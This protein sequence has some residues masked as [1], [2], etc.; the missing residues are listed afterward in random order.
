MRPGRSP[1]G[2]G[3]NARGAALGGGDPA[4]GRRRLGVEQLATPGG[5]PPSGHPAGSGGR[6]GRRSTAPRPRGADRPATKPRSRDTGRPAG[7]PAP[8]EIWWAD[9]PYADG[10]GLEGASLPGAA[11]RLRGGAD[12]LKITSQDKSDRGDHVEIPT[13]AW[14]PG[15]EHD[16]YLDLTEPIRI[17]RAAFE[18]RAGACDRRCGG[19]CRSCTASGAL[20]PGACHSS[21]ASASAASWSAYSIRPAQ[22]AGQAAIAVRRAQ[23]TRRP[24]RRSSRSRRTV[25]AARASAATGSSRVPQRR[26]SSAVASASSATQPAPVAR[27]GVAAVV[28]PAPARPPAG[29]APPGTRPSRGR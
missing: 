21:Q 22:P 18:D 17:A 7:A 28:R 16:S 29:R 23:R 6:P 8:G 27:H 13:R 15:A 9:V 3:T 10:T 2:G 14:D 5:R 25:A 20:R 4:G 11:G 1:R 19:R 26:S 12:V 24:A